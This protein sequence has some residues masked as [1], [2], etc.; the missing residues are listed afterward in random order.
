METTNSDATGP[1]LLSAGGDDFKLAITFNEPVNSTDAAILAN[2]TLTVAGAAQTLSSLAGHQLSYDATARTAQ[3]TGLRL[4][5][6]AL[7]V[8]TA[9]NIKDISGNAMVGSSSVTGTVESFA[10]SGGF[11]GPGSFQGSTFGDVKDFS[12]FGIGFMPP[13]NCAR[14]AVLSMRPALTLLNFRLPNKFPPTARL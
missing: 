12:A 6:G 8:I 9:Q 13:V 1:T 5:A 14:P 11:V 4:T 10:S 7:F 2:Y 3:L